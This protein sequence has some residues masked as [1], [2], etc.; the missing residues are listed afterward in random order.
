VFV[1][2]RK[3]TDVIYSLRVCDKEKIATPFRPYIN[4][5]DELEIQKHHAFFLPTKIGLNNQ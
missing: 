4:K 1:I 2:V 5:I 3:E